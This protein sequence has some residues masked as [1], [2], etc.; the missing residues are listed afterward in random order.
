VG[1]T[2][3]SFDAP[4]LN[5]AILALAKAGRPNSFDFLCIHPYEIADGLAAPDGE[6]PFL[7]MTRLLR[8]A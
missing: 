6:V 8:D 7:W 2:V 1:L 5:Q 4:Y 3:A